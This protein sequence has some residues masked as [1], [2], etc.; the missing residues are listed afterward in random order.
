[1]SDLS[2][3]RAFLEKWMA[4]V[5]EQTAAVSA[6]PPTRPLELDTANGDIRTA[7]G[8]LSERS[9][10][11][12]QKI[13]QMRSMLVLLQ[14]GM[15]NLLMRLSADDSTDRSLQARQDRL[16]TDAGDQRKAISSLQR[17]RAYIGGLGAAAGIFGAIVGYV[18]D[19]IHFLGH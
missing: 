8:T 4:K 14:Q 17:W 2:I 5:D 9:H 15:T 13:E 12:E 1:M 11:T 16:E 18:A 10:Q 7:I 19:H 3:S 6:S